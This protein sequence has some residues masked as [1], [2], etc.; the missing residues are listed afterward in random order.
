MD[1]EGEEDVNP[2]MGGVED[3]DNNMID[4][5]FDFSSYVSDNDDEEVESHDDHD[6]GPNLGGRNNVQGHVSRG[7]TYHTGPDAPKFPSPL[8]VSTNACSRE[9]DRK[10]LLCF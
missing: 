9:L 8:M 1:D 4:T 6:S 3:F 7:W 10:S 5:R 2:L